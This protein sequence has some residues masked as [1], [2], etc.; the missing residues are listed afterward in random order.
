MKL[1]KLNSVMN[2]MLTYELRDAEVVC[3]AKP[4]GTWSFY[5]FIKYLEIRGDECES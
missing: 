5:A 2:G 4:T 1:E 3:S